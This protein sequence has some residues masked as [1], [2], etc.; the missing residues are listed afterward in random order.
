MVLNIN[1]GSLTKLKLEKAWAKLSNEQQSAWLA[2]LE[3]HVGKSKPFSWAESFVAKAIKKSAEF[4]KGGKTFVKALI[5]AFGERS[6]AGDAVT[7]ANGQV[8]SDP[9]LSDNENVPL[10]EGVRDY[11]AREVLPHV[12]DA[13]IDETVSGPL[14]TSLRSA[15]I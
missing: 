1:A 14:T 2:A 5:N 4:G 15:T 7:D 9:D 3:P 12:P 10:K 6:P 13:Y 11:F 8:V